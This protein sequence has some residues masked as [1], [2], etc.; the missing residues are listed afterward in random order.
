MFTS[1]AFDALNVTARGACVA[2]TTTP[3]RIG[4][5]DGQIARLSKTTITLLATSLI[6]CSSAGSAR[7][8]STLYVDGD[9][10]GPS[11]DG[12]SWCTAFLYL[13]DALSAAVE[14]DEIR[15]ADGVYTP[16]RGADYFTRDREAAFGL[17]TGMAVRGG[18]AGCG[19]AEPDHRDLA[20]HES[21]LSGDLR[22][23]D[24]GF[25]N[26]YDNSYHVLNGSD[27]EET[28]ILDGFT[29]SGGNANGGPIEEHKGGGLY[30]I[31]AGDPTLINCTFV[32]NS[33][34]YHG[35][36][37]YSYD[38]SRPLLINCA[39]IGNYCDYDGGGMYNWTSRPTL[40]NCMFTGN[41]AD[42][43][44]AGVGRPMLRAP[45]ASPDALVWRSRRM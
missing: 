1:F 7:A 34:N 40:V 10:S 23:D 9:A 13:Q 38:G 20:A 4:K 25:L 36:G 41:V 45:E 26:N 29:I 30:I 11:H 33:A 39:F 24:E 21:I 18:Y 42:E 14:G 5:E 8:Q 43:D 31:H 27:T 35:G 17:L 12:T 22:G 19:A 3:G 44:G 2:G 16:D 28:A 15:V 32:G 6:V 37:M